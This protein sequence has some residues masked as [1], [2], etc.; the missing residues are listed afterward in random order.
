MK[1]YQEIF[2]NLRDQILNGDYQSGDLLPTE[3]ALQESYQASRDTIRKALA[4]LTERGFIQ[5]IQGRGSQVLEQELLQF[6]IS[7]LTSYKE[8]VNSLQ[9]NSQTKV[10]DLELIT[11]SGRL[12]KKTGFEVGQ[13]V[14][15]ILRTR[16]IDGTVSVLDLDY[17]DQSIVPELTVAIGECSI[18]SYLEEELK[19]DIAYAQ[20]E[21]TIQA[22]TEQEREW[23]DTKDESLV[24]IRSRVYLGDTRQF[25]YTE[26][27][28]R[29]DK[30]KFVDFARRKHAL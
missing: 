25:Q 28:H 12:S 17:L 2:N 23:L 29:M 30:F 16:T 1:K 10:L 20:K 15:R 7:G 27:K 5:K 14:W 24:L 21:I 22:S 11:I 18:Y 4:L 6:P 19:L 13:K 26:S 8:L 9:L 3:K